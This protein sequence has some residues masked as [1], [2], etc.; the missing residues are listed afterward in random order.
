MSETAE[1]PA[2]D[3]AEENK[4]EDPRDTLHMLPLSMVPID[5]KVLRR[6]CLVKNTKLET[7]V[8]MFS[9]ADSGSGQLYPN[10]LKDMFP[11]VD[12]EEL[13]SDVRK[14][15]KL[16]YMPSFD[17]YSCRISM[18]SFGIEVNSV[19]NLKL[20]D[21]KAGELADRMKDFTRPL[22]LQVFGS[23][24]DGTDNASDLIGLLR[25]PD[26]EEAMRRLNT[27]AEE[28]KINV[29]EIPAFIEDY[30]DIFLS[31]AYFRDRL[32][33]VVPIINDFLEWMGE[34]Q[35]TWMIKNDRPKKKLLEGV[36][37]DLSDISGSITGRFESFD[38]KTKDFWDDI[39]ADRFRE[40]RKL[41]TNHHVTVGGVLCGLTL[42]MD[43]WRKKFTKKNPGGPQ[44]RLEF[45]MGEIL[46]G[47]DQIKRLEQKAGSVT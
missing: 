12:Q 45:I 15:R 26:R 35:E 2:V 47:L 13:D 1:A 16:G 31:L 43:H 17:V 24:L 37:S 20:S 40:V 30:G 4:K 27:L 33:H 28:L 29:A 36:N 42:K 46:P 18:R 9:D 39:S 3:A 32:D 38:R 41:I 44:A 25:N 34:L 8:E 7:A 19:D 6:A 14:I 5:T 11:E 10:D 23:E 22:I 21:E